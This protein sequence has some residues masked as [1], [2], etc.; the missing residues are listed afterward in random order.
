VKM[1]TCLRPISPAPV[2]AALAVAVTLAGAALLSCSAKEGQLYDR[3]FPCNASG[4]PDQCGSGRDGKP[5]VCYPGH[6]LGGQDFCAATCDLGQ[7][8][9]DARFTCLSTGALVQRCKPMAGRDDSRYACPD[10]L[11]CYRTDLLSDEGICLMMNVCTENADCMGN[12]KA[13][14]AALVR[15]VI[16]G[17]D[18]LATDSLQC[19]QAQCETFGSECPSDQ[20]CLRKVYASGNALPDICVPKCDNAHCP[21][22][23]SCARKDDWAPGA[24]AV[25]VPGI[26]GVRCDDNDDCVIGECLDT[27]AGFHACTLPMPCR[28]LDYCASLDG[29]VDAFVCLEGVPGQPHCLNTRPLGG[30]SCTT[31]ADCAVGRECLWFSM[32]EDDP[33]HAECRLPCPPDRQ[34]AP[35]GGLPFF[36]LGENAE[37]GCYPTQF[38]APCVD[39]RECFELTCVTVGPDPRS[40]TNYN[41]NICTLHCTTDAD[42]DANHLARNRSFCQTDVQTGVGYCRLAGEPGATCTQPTH[43]RSRRCGPAGVCLE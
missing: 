3:L 17:A 28:P 8:P 20:A 14:A 4:A 19:I 23:F 30:S 26:P 11:S 31:K 6:L 13:C 39:D 10:G 18:S 27:G 24:P 33:M 1:Q 43:C 12:G 36:C 37:G 5:M 15:G 9:A 34:C 22:N 35:Q 7:A 29:P 21:P 16:A 2:R 40:H 32:F 38:G 42:C 25:C 41:P